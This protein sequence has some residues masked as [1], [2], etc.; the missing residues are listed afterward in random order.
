MAVKGMSG[1]DAWTELT[2]LLLALCGT[3]LECAA[4]GPR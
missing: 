3:P 2:D 1:A 4:P